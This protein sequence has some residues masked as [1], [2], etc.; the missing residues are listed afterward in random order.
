MMNKD[1][2]VN[3]TKTCNQDSKQWTESQ[4]KLHKISH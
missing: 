4:G 1:E 2:Y 3:L